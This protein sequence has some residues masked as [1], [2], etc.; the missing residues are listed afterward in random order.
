MVLGCSESHLGLLRYTVS[1]NI[2]E[3]KTGRVI[4]AANESEV[5][6]HHSNITILCKKLFSG[7]YM[8]TYPSFN[9]SDVV[10]MEANF[11]EGQGVQDFIEIHSGRMKVIRRHTFKDLKVASI[12]LNHNEITTLEGEAFVSLPQVV[13]VDLRDNQIIQLESTSFVSLPQLQFFSAQN[14]NIKNVPR[15]FFKFLEQVGGVINLMYNKLE[16][17][18]GAPFYGMKAENVFLSVLQNHIDSLSTEVLSGCHF[19][20]VDLEY[21]NISH[22]SND[23]FEKRTNK[24]FS[25]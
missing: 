10:E 21:N 6:V 16:A 1:T 8:F 3:E 15:S 12:S 17:L 22:I 24:S 7:Y 11:L 25:F 18:D 2:T 13:S 4:I 9:A 5:V 19:S 23:F 20:T 14:N